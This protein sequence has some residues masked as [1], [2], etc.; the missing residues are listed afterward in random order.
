MIKVGN[1]C[2]SYGRDAY[3]MSYIFG[4][5]LKKIEE[6]IYNCA[7]PIHILNRI[8]A[9]L[10]NSKLNYIVLDRR[11]NYETDLKYDNKNLNTYEEIYNKAKIY[12]NHKRRIEEINTFLVE[13]VQRKDFKEILSKMEEIIN[14][15]RK[16]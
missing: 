16:V 10:E 9:K 4:Y 13:N 12:V 5:K 11:N 3:I 7:F 2:Y 14:E 15:R 8:I 6:N 1:F